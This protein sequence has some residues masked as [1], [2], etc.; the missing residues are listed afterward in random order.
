V[1]LSNIGT[2]PLTINSIVKGGANPGDFALLSD[3]CP[4]SPSTLAVSSTCTLTVTFTPAAAG[5]RSATLTLT[6][7][8]NGVS[9]S[10][11]TVNLTGTGTAPSVGLVGL[12]G[13]NT[14]A[15]GGVPV[16]ISAPL[17]FTLSNSGTAP[18]AITS[19]VSS[20]PSEFAASSNCPASLPAN[21]NCTVSVTFTP[22]ATGPQSGTLTITDNNGGVSNS[23]QTVSLSGTGT[24]FSIS[25]TPASQTVSPGKFATYTLTLTPISGFTGT[26]SLGCNVTPPASKTTCTTPIS[27][28]VTGSTTFFS[29]SAKNSSKGT[30]TLNFFATFTATSPAT[31]TLS[32][33]PASATVKVK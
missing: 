5:A 30:F 16:G 12:S 24:S 25:V 11:Q 18:L 31:G 20:N 28:N 22:S 17:S 8:N 10:T 14:L 13:G 32:P 6:D 9:G 29:A 4:L 3:T 19:I 33:P 7:N 26:V 1:T 15:F 21:G 27:V 23:T 2:A